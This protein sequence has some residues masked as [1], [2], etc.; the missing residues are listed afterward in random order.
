MFACSF[1]VCW[2]WAKSFK[3]VS[4]SIFLLQHAFI[5]FY[6]QILCFSAQVFIGSF[7]KSFF[8]TQITL[9]SSSSANQSLQTSWEF[10]S[11]FWNW[12]LLVCKH[13]LI[14]NCSKLS[15]HEPQIL[16]LSSSCSII[17]LGIFPEFLELSEYF[18]W[19]K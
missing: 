18:S 10:F 1:F 11:I 17:S 5:F 12:F 2:E 13:N 8:V 19:L 9:L 16:Y 4:R 7:L 15:Y 3:C 6:N 14:F